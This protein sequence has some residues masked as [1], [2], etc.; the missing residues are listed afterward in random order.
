MSAEPKASEPA[1]GGS[2]PK[3]A[4]ETITQMAEDVIAALRNPA[5]MRRV[6]RRAMVGPD[7]QLMAHMLREMLAAPDGPVV[8][9]PAIEAAFLA[10]APTVLLFNEYR[11]NKLVP[12]N[13]AQEVK[14]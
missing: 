10:V 7:T 3:D 9:R 2:V 5:V 13:Q 4:N 6:A 1:K 12:K 14:A 11:G 8:N